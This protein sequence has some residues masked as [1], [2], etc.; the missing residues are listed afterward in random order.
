MTLKVDGI[1]TNPIYLNN[2]YPITNSFRGDYAQTNS[3]SLDTSQLNTTNIAPLEKDTLNISASDKIKTQQKEKGMSTATKVGL[4]VVGALATTYAC[5]VGHRMLTKPSIEKVA[6]NFSEIFRRD[7]SK[8]EAQKM[9]KE[10]KDVFTTKEKDDFVKKI[11]EQIKKDYGYQDK[12]LPLKLENL[13]GEDK[14]G[15]IVYAHWNPFFSNIAMNTEVLKNMPQKL[16][17][18]NQNTICDY[19]IHEFQH[20]KQSEIAYRTNPKRY[21]NHISN[22]KSAGD[23]LLFYLKNAQDWFIKEFTEHNHLFNS[24]KDVKEFIRKAI[25]KLE[26]NEFSDDKTILEICREIKKGKH[27][28]A[29]VVFKD[30]ETFKINDLNY[31]KGLEYLKAEECYTNA[32]YEKYSNSLLEKEAYGTADKINILYKYISNPWKIF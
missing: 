27:K 22:D 16:T 30:F 7:V 14:N 8:E 28:K 29:E 24:E 23:S 32:D 21:L 25:P 31:K 15:R 6:Q 4:T 12:K 9:V 11:F 2:G 18:K 13:G 10:Y 1:G 5:V 3:V 17:K 19:L 20:V 26:K